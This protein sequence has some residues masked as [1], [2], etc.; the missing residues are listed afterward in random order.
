V[1]PRQDHLRI[2]TVIGDRNQ[3]GGLPQ[4]DPDKMLRPSGRV[5][6][7]IAMAEMRRVRPE[8]MIG[9]MAFRAR[10]LKSLGIKARRP[11]RAA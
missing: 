9:I 2:R 7:M 1:A 3:H 10:G 11:R 6:H 8:R 5:E 4:L